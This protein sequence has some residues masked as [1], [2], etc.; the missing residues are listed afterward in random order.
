MNTVLIKTGRLL[1]LL[2][3]PIFN[4]AQTVEIHQIDVGAG[5]AALINIRNNGGTLITHSILIDAG[6][7]SQTAT[8]AVIKY[9]NDNARKINGRVYLDYIIS[10]HYDS[11]H[12]GGLVGSEVTSIVDDVTGKKRRCERYFTGVLDPSTNIDYYAVL[13]KGDTPPVSTRQI[14]A[15]YQNLARSRRVTVGE[16]VIGQLLATPTIAAPA[17]SLPTL[18]TPLLGNQSLSLGGNIDLGTDANG[19]E[20]RLK[21]ILANGKVYNR[22]ITDGTSSAIDVAGARRYY[23][24]NNNNWGLGWVLEYGTFRYYTAGDVAGYNEGTLFDIETTISGTLPNIYTSPI[25]APGHIC[26]QKIS[27][28]G[29]SHSSNPAFLGTLKSSLGV[30]SSGTKYDHPTQPVLTRLENTTWGVGTQLTNNSMAAYLMTELWFKQEK[31]VD[32]AKGATSGNMLW[33]ASNPSP[34]A[35]EYQAITP[36][37]ILSSYRMPNTQFL[38]AIKDPPTVPI[39]PG[40]V[41]IKVNAVNTV[42][43]TSQPINTYSVYSIEYERYNGVLPKLTRTINCHHL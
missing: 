37:D 6:H 33:V 24:T 40:N 42:G 14:F 15:D 2:L 22:N 38:Y 13:D 19:V 30:I 10:S 28:H 7:Y 16:F 32:L 18:P 35:P 21:L 1:L 11:D 3:L 25:G 5:D 20:V 23:N 34:T 27:H 29:S 39:I 4:W 41:V 9:L 36:T 26:A 17:T 8:Q 31:S 43:S 12:I